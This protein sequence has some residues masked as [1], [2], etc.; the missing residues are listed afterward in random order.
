MSVWR[1]DDYGGQ[2]ENSCAIQHPTTGFI[3]VA[4][5]AGVLEFDGVRWRLIG[6][7]TPGWTVNA[8]AVDRLGRIWGCTSTAVF[9]LEADEHGQLL[10]RSMNDRLPADFGKATLLARCV[11]TPD[12]VWFHTAQKLVGFPIDDAAPVRTWV[13]AEGNIVTLRLWE[14]AGEPYIMIGGNVT[15]RLH[16]G[17]LERVPGING[18]VF[19]GRI[20]PD[21]TWRL[22]MTNSTESWDGKKL[23]TRG[24]LPTGDAAYHATILAD[25]RGVFGTGR[26]GLV[27]CDR[28][29]RILQMIGREQGLPANAVAHVFEDR[30][31]GVW[32]ATRNG[33]ARVQLD[34]PYASHSM[35]QG[36]DGTIY[37][38]TRHGT[39]LFAGG[40]E[41]VAERRP[42]G[43][44][45][46]VPELPTAVREVVA[47]DDWLYVLTTRF[48]GMRPGVDRVANQLE[49]RNYFGLLPL[50]GQPGW[51][52]FGSNE[53]VNWARFEGSKW[54]VSGPLT[55][56]K[57][58]G[59]ALLESPAGVAWRSCP[60][61][62][63]P[64][65]T[66]I[67]VAA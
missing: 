17:Q 46:A 20:E 31:G 29:G 9:R 61:T 59:I 45:Q 5:A 42:D 66:L 41:G 15:F 14:L 65:G 54:V 11:V 32:A 48:R 58:R 38:M 22:L 18:T 44:F 56:T 27:I 36:L 57:G 51:F 64:P 2:P 26:H 67:F 12:G 25:G 37:S 28:D 39:R 7:P 60:K 52:V 50:A 35:A 62:R 34:S 13:A 55:A 1:A 3:Y 40:S 4:N 10:A 43:R 47:H 24:L 19:D 30:E 8:L 53:S 23:Q 21:G 63:T 49:N 33:L 16:A 6:T